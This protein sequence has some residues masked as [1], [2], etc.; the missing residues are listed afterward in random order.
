MLVHSASEVKVQLL[1]LGSSDKGEGHKRNV[2][3]PTCFEPPILPSW[4]R[5]GVEAQLFTSSHWHQ[6]GRNRSANW[7]SCTWPSS[8]LSLPSMHGTLFPLGL[9]DTSMGWKWIIYQPQLA[10]PCPVLLISGKKD[11][12]LSSGPWCHQGVGIWEWSMNS[13]VD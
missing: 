13:G 8:V 6:I 1:S 9:A 2:N 11:A 10:P 4:C 12:Q 7:S 5:V 3:Y